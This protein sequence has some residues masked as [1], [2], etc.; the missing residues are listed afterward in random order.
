[1]GRIY[2]KP[3]LNGIEDNAV[4]RALRALSTW[5]EDVDQIIGLNFQKNGTTGTPTVIVPPAAPTTH[6]ILSTT[7][8][9]TL[10]D[11]VVRGDLLY[12]NATPK[13]AR[14]PKPASASVLV[15]DATDV[16]YRIIPTTRNMWLP[17]FKWAN[18]S[19]IAPVYVQ[20]GADPDT[21]DAWQMDSIGDYTLIHSIVLPAD[22]RTGLI[23]A[24]VHWCNNGAAVVN[25]WVP[26]L[27]FLERVDG[28]SLTAAGA[29][30]TAAVSTNFAANILKISTIGT[31]NVNAVNRLN[32]LSFRRRAL[33]DAADNSSATINM[34]GVMLEY[35]PLY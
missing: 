27:R 13:V 24:K 18:V 11:T 34:L 10:V 8:S 3:A 25:N 20:V 4:Q 35:T 32:R 1:M 17:A 14:L 26:Y 28:D 2:K 23:T 5:A 7:H 19:A 22:W 12:G 30:I 29:N 31:F 21:Y 9:D 6:T 16:L 15:N 33:G